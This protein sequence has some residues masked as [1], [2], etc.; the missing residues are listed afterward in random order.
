MKNIVIVGSG[1][2]AA[3]LTGYIED[4][5]KYLTENE[6][7]CIAG[8]LDAKENIAKYWAKYK[9]YKPVLSDVYSYAVSGN[10]SFIIAISNIE[11]RKKMADVLKEKGANIISFIHP[12]SIVAKSAV[13][14]MQ[15]IIYPFCLI[16]PNAVIG[17]NN[18]IT[19]YSF[20]SHDCT[21]GDDNFFATGGLSG[22]V[23]VG[24]GNY[25]GI[26]STVLPHL[27]IG[28]RNTIQAGMTID[29]NVLNDSL[30][31]HRF[32]EKVISVTNIE[33]DE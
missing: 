11:F 23:S 14:G 31:F 30:I 4:G 26:R 3:E 25:F 2:V 8:Y 7:W 19:S 15:N 20:I 6:K 18:L 21:V 9:L 22:N 28:D 17:N 1:A 12:S 10:E 32:K 24:N 33:K 16:G 29:K 13:I 5:N 27:T